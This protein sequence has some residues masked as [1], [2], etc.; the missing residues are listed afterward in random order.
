MATVS[1]RLDALEKRIEKVEDAINLFSEDQK[2]IKERITLAIW[3]L[4]G[5]GAVFNTLG[6]EVAAKI[7][8]TLAGG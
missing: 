4:L 8:T 5:G 2:K 1:E 3:V 7:A 6:P